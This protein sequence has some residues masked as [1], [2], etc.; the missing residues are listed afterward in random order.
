MAW[1]T[2]IGRIHNFSHLFCPAQYDD[3]YF[4]DRNDVDGEIVPKI[5]YWE[6]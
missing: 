5:F 1:D 4:I 2:G 6:G 3:S